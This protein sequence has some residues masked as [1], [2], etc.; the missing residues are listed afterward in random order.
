MTPSWLIRSAGP[1]TCAATEADPLQAFGP[2]LKERCQ[3]IL[4]SEVF[5]NV[6]TS[7]GLVCGYTVGF[8]SPEFQ[9]Y[10]GSRS[11]LSRRGLIFWDAA[12]NQDGY[13]RT[14][15]FRISV[16]GP[17]DKYKIAISSYLE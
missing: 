3:V 11:L 14:V 4:I 15:A 7:N 17:Y 9:Q 10:C 12:T 2:N 13:I 5:N 1:V 16:L 6:G 8:W